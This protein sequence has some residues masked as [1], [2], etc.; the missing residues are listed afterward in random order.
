MIDFAVLESSPNPTVSKVVV[1]VKAKN[2]I[3]PNLMII[4]KTGHLTSDQALFLPY[5]ERIFI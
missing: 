3:A 1:K 4:R 5:D 2:T